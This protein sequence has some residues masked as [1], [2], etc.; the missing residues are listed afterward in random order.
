MGRDFPGLQSVTA[1]G[2]NEGVATGATRGDGIYMGSGASL[3]V[4]N[5]H[6]N[7][8]LISGSSNVTLKGPGSTLGVNMAYSFTASISCD[9]QPGST[10]YYGVLNGNTKINGTGSTTLSFTKS[11]SFHFSKESYTLSQDGVSKGS[12]LPGETVSLTAG[13]APE[14][15]NFLYWQ[16]VS[17]DGSF[18]DV[19][20]ENTTFTTGFQNTEVRPVFSKGKVCGD[21]RVEWSDGAAEPS[22]SDD[23]KIL[24]INGSGTY[25]IYMYNVKQ[26][27]HR[28]E[29]T[30]GSPMII[31]NSVKI[32]NNSSKKALI[33]K[34]N[35]VKN[36]T[37][38]LNGENE[39]VAYGSAALQLNGNPG[40]RTNVTISSLAGDGSAQGKLI[41]RNNSGCGIGVINTVNSPINLYIKGGVLEINSA[42]SVS[43]ITQYP[44]ICHGTQN[45]K[46]EI[47][48]GDIT[49]CSDNYSALPVNTTVKG[50]AT[51]EY[52]EAYLDKGQVSGKK[53][54]HIYYDGTTGSSVDSLMVASKSTALACGESLD[55]TAHIDAGEHADSTVTWSVEG[56]DSGTAIDSASGRLTVSESQTLGTLTVKVTNAYSGKTDTAAVTVTKSPRRFPSGPRRKRLP[57]G[58]RWTRQLSLAAQPTPRAAL[59]G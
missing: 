7:L 9:L 45:G 20:S 5:S 18:A 27:N 32:D 46:L 29:I 34:T 57:T 40:E 44:A 38:L 47:F 58:R 23:N 4:D 21:F 42:A 37:F 24:T 39:L 31:L 19:S 3:A 11:G 6:L 12:F 17:G 8:V 14:G 56:A 28:I 25:S 54:L 1:V 2:G 13:A 15:Q 53:S 50:S 16:L 51:I 48:G 26:T 59:P 41:V 43:D 49:S 10:E 36:I 35:A 22:F 52:N 55:F 33:L 30:G